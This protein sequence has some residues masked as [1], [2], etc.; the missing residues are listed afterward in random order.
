MPNVILIDCISYKIEHH[1][2]FQEMPLDDF[3]IGKLVGKIEVKPLFL[4][5]RKSYIV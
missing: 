4:S 5:E 1:I 3:P 2:T